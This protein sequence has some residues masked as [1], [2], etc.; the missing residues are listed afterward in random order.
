MGWGKFKLYW[1]QNF[2]NIAS[3]ERLI[4]S[5]VNIS[6]LTGTS[7]IY[8]LTFPLMA[9]VFIHNLKIL[10]GKIFIGSYLPYHLLFLG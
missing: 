3:D 9:A 5:I 10:N 1:F 4:P 6:I 8:L 2:I 7:I